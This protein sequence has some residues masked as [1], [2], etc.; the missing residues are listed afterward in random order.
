MTAVLS[1]L[2]HSTQATEYVGQ[3]LA[4]YLKSGDIL[5]L[6]GDLGAGKTALTRGIARGL[7]LTSPVSSPTFTIV[8]EHRAEKD[9]QLSLFHFDAYRLTDGDDFLDAG[10][11]EYFAQKG[12]SVIE[13]GSL[14]ENILPDDRICIFMRGTDETRAIEIAFPDARGKDLHHLQKDI[15]DNTYITE[16]VILC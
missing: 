5:T 1:L 12:V 14:V 16:G 15:S 4:L 9:G 13:W 6:D 3:K 11:D 7:G 2:S 8:I 10:L